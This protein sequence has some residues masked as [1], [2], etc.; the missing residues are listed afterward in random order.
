LRLLE[1]HAPNL[2][3][4]KLWVGET[5]PAAHFSAVAAA[6]PASITAIEI[7]CK[8]GRYCHGAAVGP[9]FDNLPKKAS[10]G[11]KRVLL[12]NLQVYDS[13]PS[14]DLPALDTLI[15][16]D[17][18]QC[19][20]VEKNA[21]GL[22]GMPA[23]RHVHLAIEWA[24]MQEVRETLLTLP[25][26]VETVHCSLVLNGVHFG[27]SGGEIPL[28]PRGGVAMALPKLKR[29]TVEMMLAESS[30]EDI[31]LFGKHL[32]FF[33]QLPVDTFVFVS[34]PED[35]LRDVLPLHLDSIHSN[36][37]E[38]TCLRIVLPGRGKPAATYNWA[39]ALTSSC[40]ARCAQLGIKLDVAVLLCNGLW[41]SQ[42]AGV[43]RGESEMEA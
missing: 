40:A 25:S 24:S 32:S 37:S 41:D 20:V 33:S 17:D 15:I 27:D 11:L 4:I 1:Q 3:A 35:Q 6:I 7:E 5:T 19:G 42:E 2:H 34:K 13:I 28:L 39:K 23:L 14:L 30:S 43:H 36:L 18:H 10:Q 12:W 29:F 22:R 8:V 31:T 16:T 9:F 38:L 21:I 26:A